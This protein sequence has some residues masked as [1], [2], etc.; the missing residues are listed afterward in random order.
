MEFTLSGHGRERQCVVELNRFLPRRSS[1]KDI[2]L[3]R[4]LWESQLRTWI[5]WITL[6]C[7]KGLF[8]SD[9]MIIRELQAPIVD[10]D[11]PQINGAGAYL[12]R[13]A[14]GL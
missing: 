12:E 1:K 13:L 7:D 9:G 10:E 11:F 6:S 2:F 4:D 5:E 8:S 14:V 3:W